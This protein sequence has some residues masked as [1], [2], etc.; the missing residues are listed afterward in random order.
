MINVVIAGS[1]SAIKRHTNALNKM[2]DIRVNGCWS[3]NGSQDTAVDLNT[4]TSCSNPDIILEKTD[5]LIIT[6]PGKFNNQLATFALRK[7]RHVFLYP[8]VL[9]STK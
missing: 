9:H 1:F 5:A 4:G 8:S 7:A 2:Q 3:S 6:D